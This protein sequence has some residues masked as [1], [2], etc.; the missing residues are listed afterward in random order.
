MLTRCHEHNHDRPACRGLHLCRRCWRSACPLHP[1]ATPPDRGYTGHRR[2]RPT[3]PSVGI[4]RMATGRVSSFRSYVLLL[5]FHLPFLAI[6]K[7]AVSAG[8]S[9]RVWLIRSK[10][11]VQIFDCDG[12][13]GRVRHV[14]PMGRVTSMSLDA[15]LDKVN[16][17]Y[18]LREDRNSCAERKR[19]RCRISLHR[20]TGFI[21]LRS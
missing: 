1:P 4:T 12:G 20:G 11:A 13:D 7:Q 8:I 10:A 6:A 19:G 9:D 14:L 3:R 18:R 21:A 17:K 5:I 2:P 15:A 16:Q